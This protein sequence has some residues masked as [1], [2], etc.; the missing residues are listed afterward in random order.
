MAT[1]DWL[2]VGGGAAGMAAALAAEASGVGSI[3]MAERGPALGGVLPQCL[4]KGF[5]VGIF[6]D[7]LTG[8][9]YASRFI[10][11]MRRSR[12]SVRLRTSVLRLCGNRSALLSGPDGVE[13]VRFRRCVLACGCREQAIGSLPVCGT[14]PAGVYTAGE[15]QRIINLE[16]LDV[17]ERAV[18]LGSGDIGQ[19]VAR[20]WVQRGRQVV[21][22]VERRDALG[23]L[24]RNQRECVEA[25]RIP[26]MLQAT[27]DELC[28][29]ARLSGV[30]VKHLD[31][32]RR[33]RLA[34]DTLITALGLI[35]E[36]SL[37][38][39]LSAGEGALPPWLALCGN[40]DYVHD[41]V[42]SVTMEAERLARGWA[43]G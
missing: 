15:A 17:G 13:T 42:D 30:W 3:L 34:C 27:V 6:G 39:G 7:S 43:K 19:I 24:P 29:D 16:G 11:R 14:R 26:V 35:P 20:H 21:A 23:G 22:M 40:C 32:G 18:V 36:R 12:V 1:C 33:E 28:G 31:T 5:G 41:I 38:G 10:E 2:I 37:L 4:H 9:E 8:A 25:C